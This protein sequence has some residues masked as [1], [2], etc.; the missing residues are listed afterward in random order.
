MS[1]LRLHYAWLVVVLL[2]PV[3]M[4]NYLDRQMMAAMKFSIMDDVASIASDEN[5]GNLLAMFKWV[6]AALSPLGGYLADR[7]GRRNVIV[8][9]LAVW[10]ALTCATGCARHY[11]QLLLFRGLMGISEACYI[12]AALALVADYHRGPTRSRAVGL[13]QMAIYLGIMIGGLSGYAADSPCLGWR[14][15]FLAAG[16]VGLV[17]AL[18]LGWLLRD[19]PRAAGRRV[20]GPAVFRTVGSLSLNPSFLLLVLYFTLP[21]LAGWLVRDWMPAVLK[22]QFNIGQGLAGFSATIWV[23][24]AALGGAVA[25]GWLADRWMRST[26]RG[27]I[28]TSALGTSLLIPALFGVAGAPTL[29][30]AAAALVLFGIGWGVFDGNNMPILCQIVRP[31]SRATAYGLMNLVSICG[32]GFADR[33]FGTLRDRH[34]PLGAIFAVFA[35]AVALSVVLVLL[36]RPRKENTWELP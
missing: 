6:Y 5:W 18:P 33:A 1:S 12:P 36:I 7:F 19:P 35:A 2:W 27:R 4:L 24:V 13:H 28:Y 26:D 22:T 10:S 30:A 15:A 29:A 9:S 32:G 16:A 23:N 21:A 20:A 34:V 25:G 31:E 17:Y 8:A 3:A 11:H 14:L